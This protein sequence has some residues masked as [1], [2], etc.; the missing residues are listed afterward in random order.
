MVALVQ[1]PFS[2]SKGSV[3]TGPEGAEA[4]RCLR[5]EQVLNLI[6]RGEK[7]ACVITVLIREVGEASAKLWLGGQRE[8]EQAASASLAV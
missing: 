4:R 7:G 1:Y 8:A 2:V 3:S 6:L 5:R